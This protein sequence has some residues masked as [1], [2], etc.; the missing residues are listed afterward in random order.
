MSLFK[1]REWWE[2]NAGEQETFDKGCLCV[3]N[4]DNDQDK[5][6]KII[7][8]SYNGIL[9]I[10]K[11]SIK[12]DEETGK[13]LTFNPDD[14]LYEQKLSEPILQVEAG[15]FISSTEQL[16]LAILHP[17]KF[18]VYAVSK[19]SGNNDRL[20]HYQLKIA[21]EHNLKRTSFNFCYGPFG[22]VKN[23]DL[24]CIQ[25]LDGSISILEQDAFSFTRHLPGALLPGPFSYV[26]STDSF[27]TVSSNRYLESYKYQIL[28]VAADSKED[29][30]SGKK[31]ASDWSLNIG[32]QAVEICVMHTSTGYMIL[33]ATERSIFCVKEN[34]K[35]IW[36]K[37][38]DLVPS[39][40]TP[41]F[42]PSS[43]N[44]RYI[45]SVHSSENLFIYDKTIMIWAAQIHIEPVAI[46]VIR[47]GE[48]KGGI[49]VLSE[50]GNIQVLYLGTDPELM[51][52][53][54]MSQ[55]RDM[56][57]A[58]MDRE[59]KQLQSIIKSK[60]SSAGVVL[61]TKRAE[62]ELEFICQPEPQLDSPSIASSEIKED[63]PSLTYK[64]T[65]KCKAAL[66][67]VALS[68][69]IPAPFA[70][71]TTLINIPHI[72][73]SKPYEH[74][75]P[76]FMKWNMAPSNLSLSTSIRFNTSQGSPYTATATSKIPLRLFA[77]NAIP[78]KANEHKITLN[79]NTDAVDLAKLFPDILATS[80][81][82][83]LAAI[84]LQVFGF[85][86]VVTILAST[87]KRYRVQSDNFTLVFG[88]VDELV[89]RLKAYH[90]RLGQYH[91]ILSFDSQLP[92]TEYFA[93]IDAHFDLRQKENE[94]SKTL[95]EKTGQLRAV[96]RRLLTRFKDKT[97]SPLNNLDTLLDSTYKQILALADSIERNRTLLLKCS[98]DLEACTRIFCLLLKLW[99]QTNMDDLEYG[100]LESVLWPNGCSSLSLTQGWHE[101]VDATIT[102]LLRTSLAKSSKDA[103][104]N[105]QPLQILTDTVKLKKHL[106][107]LIDRLS[108]G[109]KMMM[110]GIKESH[111][112]GNNE[113]KKVEIKK[114]EPIAKP[115]P[116]HRPVPM[117]SNTS[118][119]AISEEPLP[120]EEEVAV[121]KF[122]KREEPTPKVTLPSLDD[123]PPLRGGTAREGK[124][125]EDVP[126]LDDLA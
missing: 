12:V 39:A 103:T 53:P 68:I 61:P 65:I 16:A 45:L 64:V 67:D 70:T 73:A 107:L 25:S 43:E 100:I 71:P 3:A 88:V 112:V 41:F 14:V 56:D 24:V 28:A 19:S 29:S 95:G 102:F 21:Y 106:A 123:L 60:S 101:Q 108:K 17:R 125:T 13:K 62:D 1:A 52:P 51:A 32:E 7:I 31:V 4:I 79:S 72:D 99:T 109:G 105:P 117:P 84:G 22:G 55:N 122:S 91:F 23:K 20:C 126:D 6:D 118:S 78:M 93:A 97:P 110:E 82:E 114:A 77:Q 86:E 94:L 27:V 47:E 40:C 8:G 36:Q 26:P 69:H 96:Q 76:I 89:S 98:C 83:P 111:L 49:V 15:R 92:L 11:P 66:N 116:Q 115:R 58:A 10:Y 81:T 74:S 90:T 38:L 48:M 30:K 113:K 33:V 34:G 44:I 87:S 121:R 42:A 120:E 54:S 80:Q 75:F 63:V 57:Y 18:C 85:K 5:V 124:T 59:L 119:T 35:V 50:N 104:L 9:R 46:K 37:K 2:T